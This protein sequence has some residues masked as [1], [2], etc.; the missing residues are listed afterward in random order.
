VGKTDKICVWRINEK[1]VGYEKLNSRIL[2]I[3]QLWD[4]TGGCYPKRHLA[5]YKLTERLV[6][7]N[8]FFSPVL[9]NKKKQI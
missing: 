5:F 3:V 9:S 2:A 1:Y 6:E 7:M 4:L 8:K